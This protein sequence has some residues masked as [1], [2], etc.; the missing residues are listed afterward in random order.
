MIQE[1]RLVKI[2]QM[3]EKSNHVSTRQIMRELGISFDTARRDIVR[4]TETGQ[5]IRVH[6][7]IIAIDKTG[8]PGF[9]SRRQI[10]SPIK[11]KM[12]K[13][14]VKYIHPKGLYFLGSSTTIAKLCEKISGINTTIMTS[15]IDNTTIL[16]KSELPEIELLGGKVNK[17]NH[18]TYSMDSLEKIKNYRFNMAIVG[19][20]LIKD[21]HIYVVNSEDAAINQRAVSVARQVVLIAEKYKFSSS[22]TSPYR[23]MD[24]KDVDMLISDVPLNEENKSYFRKD[25]IFKSAMNGDNND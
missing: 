22:N 17:E 12:A 4:L 20:S 7:G 2:K 13:L 23:I 8:V 11:T 14:L 16:L 3:L 18:F 19:A 1:E 15:S 21:G 10:E 25:C 5:A 6:G 9:T 24:C